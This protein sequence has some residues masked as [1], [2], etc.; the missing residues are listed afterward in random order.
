VAIDFS[1]SLPEVHCRDYI[2]DTPL[3]NEAPQVEECFFRDEFRVH[4]FPK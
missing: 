2:L 4:K 3:E 1:A